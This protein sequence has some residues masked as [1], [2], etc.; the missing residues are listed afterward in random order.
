[1]DIKQFVKDNKVIIMS[2]SAICVVGLIVVSSIVIKKNTAKKEKAEHARLTAVTAQDVLS[3]IPE[4]TLSHVNI[5]VNGYYKTVPISMELTADTTDND[6][7]YKGRYAA[8]PQ[9][10]GI[11]C[12]MEQYIETIGDI[13]TLYTKN[14]I[15]SN[16]WIKECTLYDQYKPI[17]NIQE[18]IENAKIDKDTKYSGSYYLITGDISSENFSKYMYNFFGK[19]GTDCD[20]KIAIDKSSGYIL[21]VEFSSSDTDKDT[22]SAFNNL[23]CDLEYSTPEQ[24]KDISI[25]STPRDG[26]A[27]EGCFLYYIKQQI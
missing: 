18:D 21:K 5:E 2:I 15:K 1:M 13:S 27:E 7:Y 23:V 25:D 22:N 17:Y 14:P 24:A 3:T 20:V 9:N 6:T 11:N 4:A 26:T 19:E 8:D 12:K 10:D 16:D